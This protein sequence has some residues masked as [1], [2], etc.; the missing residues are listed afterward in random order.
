MD[1]KVSLKVNEDVITGKKEG[2]ECASGWVELEDAIKFPI[3][4]MKYHSKEENKDKIFV[5]YPNKK[6]TNGYD[7]I[8]YPVDPDVRE[9]IQTAIFDELHK[10]ILKGVNHPDIEE[11]K[12]TPF[13]EEKKAGNVLVKGVASIKTCG[14]MINGI[15]IK[16][17]SKGLFVQMPQH[18]AANGE[19]H[20]TVYGTN[21]MM[22]SII[23]NAVLDEYN[24]IIKNPP[25]APEPTPEPTPEQTPEPAPQPESEI[26]I[27]NAEYEGGYL[28]FTT[29]VDGYELNSLFRIYDPANGPDMTLV[30]IEH[31]DKHPR[32][33]E[34]WSGIE[35]GLKDKMQKR[36]ER[37]KGL[38]Q[39]LPANAEQQK[40][41]PKM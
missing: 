14:I 32:I 13:K 27:S 36:Y 18:R 20:D 33:A 2:T 19:F 5:S 26:I 9:E 10:Q 28:H 24:N 35:E 39:K 8:L 6:G 17:S 7:N 21:P 23:K 38:E 4:L 41:V 25:K 15:L 16:E 40:L 30:S 3:R 1:I 22:Q 37:L 29:Q 12:V 11:V 31:G 34:V